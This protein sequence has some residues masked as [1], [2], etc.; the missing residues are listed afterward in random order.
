MLRAKALYSLVANDF[1][2]LEV[3]LNA[4]SFDPQLRLI[5]RMYDESMSRRIKEQLDI[6]LTFSVSAMAD[7]KFLE[8]LDSASG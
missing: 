7:E 6:H 8:A 5:I 2:N 1:V 4:R 3:G